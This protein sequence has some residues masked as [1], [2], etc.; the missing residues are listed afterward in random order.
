MGTSKLKV[1]LAERDIQIKELAAR[2][3]VPY[4]T[5]RGIVNGRRPLIN[6]AYAISEAL[7]MHIDLVFPDLYSYVQ[8]RKHK[9]A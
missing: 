2:S 8:K 4:E 3:G 7:N 6:N 5:L 1:I 9:H